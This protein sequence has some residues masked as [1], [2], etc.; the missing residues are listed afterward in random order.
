MDKNKILEGNKLIAQF[1]GYKYFPY[2]DKNPGWRKERWHPN[3]SDTY[4]G[5]SHKDLDFNTN[6][7]SLMDVVQKIKYDKS[8][9]IRLPLNGIDDYIAPYINATRS[10]NRAL[11]EAKS[12]DNLWYAVVEFIKWYEKNKPKQKQATGGN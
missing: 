1:L 3:I 4:L 2:P 6:W 5:R 8:S 10:I 11:I 7:N 9:Q 12:I